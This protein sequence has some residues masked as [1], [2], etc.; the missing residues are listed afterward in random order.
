MRFK[1]GLT[2]GIAIGY[3]LGARAGRDR[4]ES[5]KRGAASVSRHPAI[6]QLGSQANGLTDLFR[7]GVATGLEA[8]SKG[9]RLVATD[10]PVVDLTSVSGSD[11]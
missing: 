1:A 5:I 8:G 10:E 6:A 7:S 11:S 2:I 3:V 4:Y 9:L